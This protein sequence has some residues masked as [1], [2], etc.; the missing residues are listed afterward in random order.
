MWPLAMA[1]CLDVYDA[2][3]VANVVHH[4]STILRCIVHR[5]NRYGTM[6]PLCIQSNNEAKERRSNCCTNPKCESTM[7]SAVRVQRIHNNFHAEQWRWPSDNPIDV[8]SI[9]RISQSSP[10]TT[11]F[12]VFDAQRVAK[13]ME[14]KAQCEFAQPMSPRNAPQVHRT[15]LT[16]SKQ[17]EMATNDK[18]CTQQIYATFTKIHHHGVCCT[19]ATHSTSLTQ[20]ESVFLL[21]LIQHLHKSSLHWIECII[22]FPALSLS[23]TTHTIFI[24]MH[25]TTTTTGSDIVRNGSTIKIFV[26]NFPGTICSG[27][28]CLC[29]GIPRFSQYDGV[30]AR[31]GSFVINTFVGVAQAFTLIFC[32]VGWGWSIWWGM[33]MLRASSNY[34]CNLFNFSHLNHG[35]C[36]CVSVSAVRACEYFAISYSIR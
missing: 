33:I 9:Q 8:H 5:I 29:L 35:R 21:G 14:T 11:T 4:F 12:D 15:H 1:R 6:R 13:S 10:T 20:S 36:V 25:P 3:A 24:L 16:L 26:I 31:I 19:I 18:L 34:K 23:L 32:L 7:A 17:Y 30:R 27:V 2:H 28:F 22:H